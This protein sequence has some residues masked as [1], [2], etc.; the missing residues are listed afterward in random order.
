MSE[1]LPR[2]R[3]PNI[4]RILNYIID[5]ADIDY[6]IDDSEEFSFI[7]ENEGFTPL[8]I[9]RREI[10]GHTLEWDKEIVMTDIL[11]LHKSEDPLEDELL[12]KRLVCLEQEVDGYDDDDIYI[13]VDSG[14]ILD[15]ELMP[16][17]SL[18]DEVARR[19]EIIFESIK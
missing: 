3:H 17:D 9:A 8:C 1:A 4:D 7:S 11:I 6:E 16:D 12:S 14:A 13:E 19:F 18:R 2:K 5:L 15:D 10:S